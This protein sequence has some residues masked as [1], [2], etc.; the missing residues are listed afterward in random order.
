MGL[1]YI[2]MTFTTNLS[3]CF[4][5]EYLLTLLK[6]TSSKCQNIFS[7]ISDWWF[8]ALWFKIIGKKIQKNKIVWNETA[9]IQIYILL[10]GFKICLKIDNWMM[11][12]PVPHQSSAICHADRHEQTWC[13]MEIKLLHVAGRV[14]RQDWTLNR[15]FCIP[16]PTGNVNWYYNKA[17]RTVNLSEEKGWSPPALTGPLAMSM[18][19][20]PSVSMELTLHSRSPMKFPQVKQNRK[21]NKIWG[22]TG[23]TRALQNAPTGKN[24]LSGLEAD[25]V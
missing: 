11:L 18:W 6:K 20:W 3:V 17:W 16:E 25:R 15:G 5:K 24:G 2:L 21:E 10:A 13:L 14:R 8:I 22:W 4:G 19:C 12:V 9:K 1:N 23:C 7:K